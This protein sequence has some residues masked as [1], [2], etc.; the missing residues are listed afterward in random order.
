MALGKKTGGRKK[1]TT[2]KN[3]L[4]PKE[5]LAQYGPEALKKL[6]E[7]AGLVEGVMPALDEGHQIMCLRDICDRAFGKPTQP[8][9]DVTASH[10]EKLKE[11]EQRVEPVL[12]KLHRDTTPTHDTLR[13][14]Q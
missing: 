13:T 4:A 10:E 2:N 14:V 3:K 12:D 5:M 8:T 1:G 6:A 11:L 9:A 7:K